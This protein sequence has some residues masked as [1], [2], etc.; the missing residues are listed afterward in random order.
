VR[1]LRIIARLNIGGPAIHATLLSQQLDPERYRTVLVSGSE[2]EDEGSYLDL[3]GRSLPGL[4]RIPELG[5][6]IRGLR[7]VSAFRQLVGLIQQTKPHIVHT[8][9]AKAGTLGRLAA[10]WCGVPIVVHTYHGHVFHGYFPPA[11]TRLFVAIERWLGRRTDCLIAVSAQVRQ[12]LLALAIGTPDRFEVVRLGLDLE[13]LA[14]A[15]AHRGAL[16]RE[17]ALPADVPTI[18]I[19][20]RLVPIKAHEIF[21]DAARRIVE[22]VSDARFIVVGDGERRPELEALARRLGLAGQTHFLGWRADLDRIYAGL[23]V[24]ALTSRNEGSP[25]ALI[26]AMAAARPI[27][28]T[29]VGGVADLITDGRTGMLVAPGDGAAMAAG[30]VSLL[31]DRELAHRLGAAA[32]VEALGAYGATRLLHDV[33]ALYQRLLAKRAAA[34]YWERVS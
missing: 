24:V 31:R 11:K 5:R 16:H 20:A 33:D 10:W 17:L 19:V 14:R 4:T 2:E 18:G 21:F 7:D 27:V 15:D 32:R 34:A 12:E 23:D 26:E 9:T 29:R 25:V 28:A 3:T 8:H 1:V 22:G 6:E 13:P 30:I